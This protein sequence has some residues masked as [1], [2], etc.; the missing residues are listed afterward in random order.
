MSMRGD[1]PGWHGVWPMWFIDFPTL[2]LIIGA[3]LDLG[4]AG[5]FGWNPAIKYFG[6]HIDI[7]Y[8]IVGFSAAWQ[9]CRQRMV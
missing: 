7:A 2:L 5:V 1:T 6:S 3:G 4:L 8:T 9:L